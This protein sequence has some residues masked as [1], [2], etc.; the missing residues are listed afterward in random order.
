MRY[1]EPSIDAAMRQ[2]AEQGIERILV[3]PMYPQF[4]CSTTGSIYDAVNR[5]AMGRRCPWFFDRKRAMPTLRFVPPYYDHPAY[6]DALATRVRESHGQI[7]WQPDCHLITFHGIPQR[8]VDEGDPYR[9]HCE[10]TPA[11]WR[12]PSNWRTRTGSSAFNRA[13]QR[14]WLQPYT[15]ET[16]SFGENGVKNLLATC[17]VHLDCLE[18]IDEIGREGEEEFSGGGGE[19]FHLSPASTT[20]PC[21]WMPWPIA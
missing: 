15:D 1:G 21:G 11:Y 7:E 5:A 12:T 17:P 2:F 14:N 18:T 6:I 3:F 9:S 19:K 8:Y 16:L 13:W 4:S 20:I 10:E